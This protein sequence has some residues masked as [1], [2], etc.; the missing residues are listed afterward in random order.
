VLFVLANVVGLLW[1]YWIWLMAKGL[2]HTGTKVSGSAA[3]GVTI[4]LT[5]LM[6]GAGVVMAF[7]FGSFMS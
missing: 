7:L 3:W 5:V 1:I 2:Q 4:T 6:V